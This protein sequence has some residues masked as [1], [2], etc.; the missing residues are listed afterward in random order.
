MPKKK[1]E[2]NFRIIEYLS[3]LPVP[4]IDRRL[5]I[6]IYFRAKARSNETGIEHAAKQYHGLKKK[7]IESIPHE[8][9]NPICVIS[10]KRKKGSMNYYLKRKGDRTH[11]IKLSVNLFKDDEHKAYIKTLFVTKKIIR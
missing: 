11:M 2:P 3:K 6:E 5:N 8:I 1:S 9:N 10:D 4:I 7:D